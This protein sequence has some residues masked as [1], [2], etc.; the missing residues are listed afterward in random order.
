M[1]E[2][3]VIANSARF[4]K[5]DIVEVRA[6]S[7]SHGGA[8]V[9][10]T[11]VVIKVPDAKMSDVRD[12]AKGWT[13]NLAFNEVSHSNQRDL[14]KL[15][16]SVSNAGATGAGLDAAQAQLDVQEWGGVVNS[17]SSSEIDFDLSVEAMLK[18]RGLLE[19]DVSASVFQQTD[20]TQGTGRHRMRWDYSAESYNTSGVEAHLESLGA[21]IISHA[22][23]VI[24]FEMTRAQ[25][26][27]KFDDALKQKHNQEIK[28]R[29]YSVPE[30]WVDAAIAGDG[31]HTVTLADVTANVVD[32]SA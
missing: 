16:I 2:L 23:R 22:N 25:A 7:H 31:T 18:S 15:K 9:P 32:K 27:T 3:L 1:A 6:N 30:A 14:Y 8:E 4:D 24:E 17:A 28:K 21:T 29:L 19:R 5:G 11:F 12:Y 26:R 20:Y 13:K 10:N